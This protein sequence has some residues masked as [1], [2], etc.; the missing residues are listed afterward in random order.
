MQ[1]A[2]DRETVGINDRMLTRLSFSRSVSYDPGQK[3]NGLFLSVIYDADGNNL[4]VD[5]GF[6]ECERPAQT[7][8]SWGEG[9]MVN[10]NLPLLMLQLM[11]H[12]PMACKESEKK[13]GKLKKRCKLINLCNS[14]GGLLQ[15]HAV[16]AIAARTI[17]DFWGLAAGEVLGGKARLLLCP[18]GFILKGYFPGRWFRL[19]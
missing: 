15:E 1:P 17:G 10:R 2:W 4:T 18:F 13:T 3:Y 8:Q 12:F 11:P 5:A 14:L 16:E 19:S 6:C 7:T 9:A